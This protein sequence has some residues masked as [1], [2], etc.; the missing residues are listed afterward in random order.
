MYILSIASQKGGVGKTTLC[1]N[2]AV[3]AAYDGLATAVFDF[4]PQ[5]TAANWGDRREADQPTIISAQVGR[6][7]QLVDKARA[8][9]FDL[10][11]IDT[12]PNVGAEAI[13]IAKAADMVLVPVR[14][15]AFDLEAMTATIRVLNMADTP[16]VAV[17][18]SCKPFGKL[19]DEARDVVQSDFGFPVAPQTIGDRTAFAHAATSGEGVVESE[20]R[21]KAADEV[22]ALWT[23]TRA[24]LED[25]QKA[26]KGTKH[27]KKTA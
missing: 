5:T 13:D 9:G 11:V 24:A 21:S 8:D 17:L 19:A 1:L 2:L 4:D 26:G 22:R 3:A 7:P 10:I 6:L 25:A 12:P 23:W 18:N 14:P 20:P 27:G 15:A 16:G